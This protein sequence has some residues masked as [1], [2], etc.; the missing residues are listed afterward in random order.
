MSL[1]EELFPASLLVFLAAACL[2]DRHLLR[3][4]LAFIAFA[5]LMSLAWWRLDA[6]WLA[7]VEAMLGALLTGL[8]LFHGLG[9]PGTRPSLPV[10]DQERRP[11]HEAPVRWLAA[12]VWLTLAG[13]AVWGI[14]GDGELVASDELTRQ[15]LLATGLAI[16]A[17]GLWAFAHH[18]HLLRRLLAFNVLGSGVFLLLAGLAG[19]SVEVQGLILVGLVV[20]L[21][22]SVLGAALLRRLHALDGRVTLG[23]EADERR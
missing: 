3:A 5:L 22:G 10:H 19:P 15:P 20:A 4:C 21:I 17:L 14:S 2:L 8:A 11:R 9:Y 23:V 12:L 13:V 1:P 7:L 16:M 18:L 6:P